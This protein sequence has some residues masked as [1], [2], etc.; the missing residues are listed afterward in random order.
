MASSKIR[1]NNFKSFGSTVQTFSKKPITLIYGPNSVGKSSLLH[2]QLLLEYYKK[3]KNVEVFK[4][5]FFGDELDFGG[6]KNII[7]KH[8]V[9]NT[10]LYEKIYTNKIGILYALGVLVVYSDLD[11][12]LSAVDD[13]KKLQ[14]VGKAMRRMI[15]L[16][17]LFQD[18]FFDGGVSKVMIVEK[19]DTPYL[20]SEI[21]FKYLLQ[22]ITLDYLYELEYFVELAS[23]Q[24]I[25]RSLKQD[26]KEQKAQI[27]QNAKLDYKKSLKSNE[28]DDVSDEAFRAKFIDM[29]KK[30]WETEDNLEKSIIAST[31][32]DASHIYSRF[33][34]FRYIS[35]I[36]SIKTS[37]EL[38]ETSEGETVALAK[39]FIDNDE[40]FSFEPATKKIFINT[41]HIAIEHFQK[42][43]KKYEPFEKQS[44]PF[45]DY[46]DIHFNFKLMSDIM[47]KSSR[48]IQYYGPLRH[49]PERWEMFSIQK[50][51]KTEQAQKSEPNK[52]TV[53]IV[54]IIE[55]TD[56]F[57]NLFVKDKNFFNS[58]IHWVC[59][60]LTF[61][62]IYFGVF[63]SKNFKQF[64]T[65]NDDGINL[66]NRLVPSRFQMLRMNKSTSIDIW[67]K[68][69]G[70]DNEAR[71]KLN[72]WLKDA[73]RLKSNYEVDVKEEEIS[74]VQKFG[75]WLGSSL[76]LEENFSDVKQYRSWQTKKDI[77]TRLVEYLINWLI[78]I[79]NTI[80][81]KL[82]L[83]RYFRKQLVFKD[84]S[85]DTEVTPRDMGLGISQALPI[86]FS[87]FSSK[88]THIYL[89]QPELHL[90]PA[91][92]MELA[93]EFIRSYHENNNSFM[94][95]THSEHILLR[96]MKRMRQTA[97]DKKDRDKSLDLTPDDVCLLYVDSHKGKTFLRELTLDEHGKLLTRWPSGFFDSS[98]REMF[99]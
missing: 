38:S 36:E 76:R 4:T 80:E 29:A 95:E 97:A 79:S 25:S 42:I 71:N 73:N 59:G 60:I 33:Q 2:S 23:T 67:K 26:W 12:T 81:N 69:M 14:L 86:L 8:D 47:L 3:W 37:I 98:Y 49:Y 88:K 31:H 92:Q 77:N 64:M 61:F 22:Y 90:H 27:I 50:N 43:E 70:S 63:A 99:S 44:T 5:S 96:I 6:F 7:H 13:E 48:N 93:D 56:K 74:R 32:T 40:L 91:V 89:E 87:A 41:S 9:S 57:R 17:D 34:F 75:Y 19:L 53:F 1:F 16:K 52:F 62:L 72:N 94:I 20:A 15:L 78:S 85:K 21:K 82:G 35:T 68:L 30:L 51:A 83:T 24:S 46:S 84:I 10:L 45:D 66:Y 55:I 65:T 11:K 54:K 58:L 28:S 18:G 39:F